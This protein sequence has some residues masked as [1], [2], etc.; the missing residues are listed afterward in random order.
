MDGC[1]LVAAI[2]GEVVSAGMMGKLKTVMQMLTIA[3]I[4]LNNLPFEMW[5][6]PVSDVMLWFSAFIS[7]ASGIQYYN[8]LK[9]Y[10]LETK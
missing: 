1:R 9:P 8:Q 10:I 4:L 2:N 3:L 7:I 5:S 6:L